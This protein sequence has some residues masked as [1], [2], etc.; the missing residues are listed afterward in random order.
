M[1]HERWVEAA[2]MENMNGT[3]NTKQKVLR[4][5][6]RQVHRVDEDIQ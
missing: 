1:V 5:R 2:R 6:F 4:E 3:E